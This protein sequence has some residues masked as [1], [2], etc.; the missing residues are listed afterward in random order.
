LVAGTMVV[1][2]G[3]LVSG[4]QPGKKLLGQ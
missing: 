3:E 1:A 4:V 2:S